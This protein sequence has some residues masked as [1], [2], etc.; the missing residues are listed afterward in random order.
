MKQNEIIEQMIK[1]ST[2]DIEKVA[3]YCNKE[4]DR[5]ARREQD[6]KTEVV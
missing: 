3:L 6:I 5:R 2:R 4:L 1:L